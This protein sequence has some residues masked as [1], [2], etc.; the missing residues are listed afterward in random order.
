LLDDGLAW[1]AFH[2]LSFK[3]GPLFL[4]HAHAF[5]EVTTVHVNVTEAEAEGPGLERDPGFENVGVSAILGFILHPSVG[6]RHD[7]A[8]AVS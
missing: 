3:L 6:D 5:S 4:A 8:S 2:E 7:G 1:F